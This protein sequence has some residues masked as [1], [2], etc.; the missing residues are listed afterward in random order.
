[1]VALE[2]MLHDWTPP[3]VAREVPPAPTVRPRQED[4][5]KVAE[6]VRNAKSPVIVTETAGRDP[7]AFSALAEFADLLAIAVI[8]GRVNAYAIFPPNPPLSPGGGRNRGPD[9]PVPARLG[10]PP[11]PGPPPRRRP[12]SGKIVAIHDHPF[13]EHMVYQSLHADCYLEGDIAE[14]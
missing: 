9:A 5:A 3:A 8:N 2:H 13:K 11:A 6:L 1:N 4:V 10:G 14:S 7:K 12:T